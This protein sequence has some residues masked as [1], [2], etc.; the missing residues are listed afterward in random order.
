M[1]KYILGSITLILIFLFLKTYGTVD[2]KIGTVDEKIGTVDEKIKI[3]EKVITNNDNNL[4]LSKDKKPLLNKIKLQKKHHNIGLN[5]KEQITSL[6]GLDGLDGEAELRASEM[7]ND[8]SKVE[9]NNT[10]IT[11]EE[12]MENEKQIIKTFLSQEDSVDEVYDPIIEM[13]TS[14]IPNDNL[15]FPPNE[16]SDIDM[17]TLENIEKEMGLQEVDERTEDVEK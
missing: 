5:K 13:N 3:S 8:M 16:S 7:N 1:V 9:V 15:E 17:N 10:P 12:M 4:T 2:E 6:D 11:E 14:S